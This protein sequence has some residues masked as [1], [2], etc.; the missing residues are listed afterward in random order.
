MFDY[1]MWRPLYW[2]VNGVEPKETPAMSLANDPTWS[3]GNKTVTF[4]L[5]S[6]Y[7]WSDGTPITSKDVLFWYDEMK[8]AIKAS[9]GQLGDLHARPRHPGPGG[10]HQRAELEHRP[11]EPHQGR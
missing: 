8:A 10:E 9:P 3:N 4:T 1:Q 11:D 2:L 6:N 7:K 5:K